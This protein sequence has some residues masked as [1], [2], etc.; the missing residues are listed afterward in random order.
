VFFGVL[1]CRLFLL[2][3]QHSHILSAQTYMKQNGPSQS[4]PEDDDDLFVDIE[5]DGAD[6]FEDLIS[7]PTDGSNIEVVFWILLFPLRVLMHY[8]I[9][10]VRSLDES[11]EATATKAKAFLA[12]FM[13]LVWLVFGSYAMVASLEAL[14]ALMDIPDAVIGFTVSAAGTILNVAATTER[15]P[16]LISLFARRPYRYISPKLRRFQSCCRKW[17]RKSSSVQ[18]LWVQHF[19]YNDWP[20]F[21]VD[22]VHEFRDTFRTISWLE[23]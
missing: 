9:P 16:K 23:G 8:T 6:D 14:A 12:T 18:R 11:G 20:R 21:T 15:P 4:K 13:C 19:Q 17:I 10:D 7:F 5:F 2:R 22:V 3:Q 1:P